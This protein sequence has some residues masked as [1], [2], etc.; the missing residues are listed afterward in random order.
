MPANKMEKVPDSGT[1]VT[2]AVSR[3]EWVN[4]GDDMGTPMVGA[5]AEACPC[6][7]IERMPRDRHANKEGKWDSRPRRGVAGFMGCVEAALLKFNIAG[8]SINL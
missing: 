3:P 7:P 8:L 2:P 4:R 1:S 5:S 6:N